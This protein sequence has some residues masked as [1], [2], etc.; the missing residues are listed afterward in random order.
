MIIDLRQGIGETSQYKSWKFPGGE[1]HF[2]LSFDIRAHKDEI[3]ILS[4][5][6][7]SDDI[8]HLLIAADTI[9]SE[10]SYNKIGL[11][12]PYM[13][14]QQADRRFSEGECFSLKTFTNLINSI[15]F[16][17][18]IIGMP[19]SDVS[20]ALINNSVV[21]DNTEF[22]KNV[23]DD[24][25][26]DLNNLVI[27]SPDAGAYKTVFKTVSK[28]KIDC[29][30]FSCSKSRSHETGVIT[31]IV[32]DIDPEKTVLI[33]DDI[34][35]GSRTFLGIKERLKNKNV[36][37]AVSHGIFNENVSLVSNTFTKIYTT[38]SR[39]NNINYPDNFEIVNVF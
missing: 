20:P 22:I 12:I 14:Y 17:K 4:K 8:I 36:Y 16:N 32:P 1:I 34:A 31:T 23:L 24:I 29:Q 30:V 11:V 19:H 25:N 33:I 38:N 35:L 21:I 37:L 9:K 39:G 3:L 28:L 6:N 2:K 13:P 18:V 5:L 15:G 10:C 26:C 27:L 7:S